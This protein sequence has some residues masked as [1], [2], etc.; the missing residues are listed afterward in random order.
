MVTAISFAVALPPEIGLHANSKNV[1]IPD[2]VVVVVRAATS[3]ISSADEINDVAA[4]TTTTTAS[5]MRTFLEFACKPI[6]GG[7]ATANEIAVTIRNGNPSVGTEFSIRLHTSGGSTY[8]SVYNEVPG[9]PVQLH[10]GA[11]DLVSGEIPEIRAAVVEKKVAV[12]YRAYN[13]DAEFRTWTK[14]Y[15]HASNSDD[16]TEA[17]VVGKY[18]QIEWGHLYSG[19]ASTQN[20]SRWYKLQ[21][22]SHDG[23]VAH[24]A[25]PRLN[26]WLNYDS[27]EN[28]GGRFF[29]T[30]PIYMRAG[31]KIASKDGPAVKGD[32][33]QITPRH[34]Y[35]IE[36]I[37]TEI[38]PSPSK[39][40]ASNGTSQACEFVWDID[41]NQTTFPLGP[42]RALY[43]GNI[44]FRSCILHGYNGS[45]WS[46]IAVIDAAKQV[47]F[48]R[49]G[50]AVTAEDSS[51]SSDQTG[52]IFWTFDSLTGCTFNFKDTDAASVYEITGN[53][54]G[55]FEPQTNKSPVILVD[56]NASTEDTAGD[57]QI[58]LKDL[59]IIIPDKLEDAYEKIK[60]EIPTAV[61]GTALANKTASGNWEIG[62][63]IWGH[64][65]VF[66]RQ[67]SNG[68]IRQ[69]QANSE[70]FTGTGGQRRAI[71]KGPARR[72]VE[73]SWV[74]PVDISPLADANPSPNY[75]KGPGTINRIVATTADTP[76]LMQGLISRL[77]GPVTPVVYLPSIASSPVNPFQI[78][79][80]NRMLYGRITTPAYRIENQLGEEWV[81]NGAG[82]TVTATAIR[83]EE[84]L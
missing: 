11:L 51:V 7:S 62:T 23:E 65:A 80:P 56:G 17:A 70:M 9:T 50:N 66:G 60:L 15:E 49:R 25:V 29:S 71:K 47:R 84:E 20:K 58:W 30:A 72:A 3:L 19:G 35:P 82:E 76:F 40:W 4:R 54:E 18:C 12:Y 28:V 10:T 32:E 2:A 59:C 8:L 63:I 55:V 33:W 81:G 79:D 39:V 16:L 48:H 31:L 42:T 41:A 64:V 26:D 73:F 69:I 78:M 1:R 53:S 44:N 57:G 43:L 38:A 13:S 5:G 61:S 83:I 52:D 6:S 21:V 74:D 37:H 75:V 14:A 67:Y 77:G 24:S 34:D 45:T 68:H 22:G 36:A 46:Q 27:P